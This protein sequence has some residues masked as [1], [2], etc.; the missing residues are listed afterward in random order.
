MIGLAVA[1]ALAACLF[2]L[3]ELGR[4]VGVR[5]RARHPEAVDP[6][7]GT[8]ETAVVGLLGLLIAFTFA[9]AASRFEARRD[10]VVTEANAI[11][12]AWLRLDLLPAD[13]RDALRA[14]F[15]QYADS[16]IATYRALPDLDAAM[17]EIQRSTALQNE[18]WSQAVAAARPLPSHAS[19]L[20]IP[21]LNDMIDITTTRT[22]AARTHAPLLI[23]LTLGAL[24][25]VNSFLVGY[26]MSDRARRSTL[27][28]AGFAVVMALT[29]LM[30][31]DLEFPRLGWIRLDRYDQVL[32][33][34]RASM[35]P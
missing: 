34:V 12:T 16:R 28:A 13:S 19:V 26:G 14:K 35:G 15:R 29:T 22:A 1:A 10:L 18:I 11:G 9:D 24:L 8:V 20:L 6:G 4:R 33:D 7:S 3:V 17:A 30:I 2:G 32:L 23:F 31:L 27:H 5:Q 21:A 25:L